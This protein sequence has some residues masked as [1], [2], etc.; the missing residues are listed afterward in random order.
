MLH[1]AVLF[2][3]R[4]RFLLL[5]CFVVLI[6]TTIFLFSTNISWNEVAE[7]QEVDVISECH[8]DQDKSHE[9]VSTWLAW[10]GN[11]VI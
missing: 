7:K 11:G 4:F 10:N 9:I 3:R 6:F 5:F 2:M 8:Y 1:F